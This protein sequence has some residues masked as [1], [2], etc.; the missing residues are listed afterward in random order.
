MHLGDMLEIIPTLGRFGAVVTDA[1]FGIQDAPIEGSKNRRGG[2]NTWHAESDWDKELNPAWGVVCDAA[3][4]VAWFG[5]WRKREA[6]ANFIRFPLRAEIVWAKDL[7]VGPPSPVAPRDERI[8]IFGEKGIKGKTFET[9]VWDVATI[10]SWSFK[11]H[12][13][14]KPIP[15]MERLL[16]FL[17]ESNILDP[18]CGSGSTGVAAVKQGR[19]F[20]GIEQDPD[21]FAVACK[22]IAA[23]L[24][25]PDMFVAAPKPAEQL[26]ILTDEKAA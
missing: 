13:N 8:W 4:I 25:E 1:P 24:R 7:H 9:S 12:K 6:V 21:H 16:A 19:L 20:T 11:H 23:A 5:Q 26:S 2:T 22:R 14:E 3:P 10:P 17:G 15:L 18:F